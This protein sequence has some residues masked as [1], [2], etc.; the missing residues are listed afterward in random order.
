M[1]ENIARRLAEGIDLIQIREKDLSA[2]ALYDLTRRVLALPNPKGTRILVNGRVDV[3]L[4]A[5]ADGVHLPGDAPSAALFRKLAPA[6]FQ[7]GVSCHSIEDL[8]R[9]EAE[10][11]DFAV[12]G[13]VF[14]PL[15]KISS[16]PPVGLQ[17]LA[18]AAARVSIPIFALGGITPER[19]VDC[20]Y[21]GAAGVAA[22]TWFQA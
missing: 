14:A 19:E 20:L 17:G 9:A 13:P 18:A 22:I 1:I 5:R 3:A 8:Q 21:A 10:G 7:I 2:R 15:S 12:Y 4:A 6:G 16:R 11:A